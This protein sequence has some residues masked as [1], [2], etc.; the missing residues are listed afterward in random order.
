MISL[1]LS[2]SLHLSLGL[3]RS[4]KTSPLIQIVEVT[5]FRTLHT[6]VNLVIAPHLR[7][8]PTQLSVEL[9]FVL[10]V[11][12]H[13]SS[14]M[15]VSLSLSS[16]PYLASSLVLNR[17]DE[18]TGISELF[19]YTQS[20]ELSLAD[21]PSFHINLPMSSTQRCSLNFLSL[22]LEG[23]EPFDVAPKL[24]LF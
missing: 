15:L 12:M 21:R 11:P 8:Q 20:V 7:H 10:S 5:K 13:F 16:F 23:G 2:V 24:L 14:F 9:I 18:K 1:S 3:W 6:P 4:L 17:N 22:F 19:A